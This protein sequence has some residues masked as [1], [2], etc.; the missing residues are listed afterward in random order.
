M[1]AYLSEERAPASSLPFGRADIEQTIPARF[2]QIVRC[3]PENIALTGEGHQWT[4]AEL[5][6]RVNR[7]AHAIRALTSPHVG[8]VAFLLKQSPEMVIATLAVLKAGKTYL[9]IHPEMPAA[10]QRDIVQDAAPELIVTSG[11]LSSRAREIAASKCEILVVDEIDERYSDQNLELSI[12]PQDPSSIFYTSGTTGN[13]KGVVKSH[14]AV[15]HRVWLSTQHDVIVPA[16]RQSLLT[17]ASFSASESDMFAALLQGARVCVFDIGSRGFAEFRRW[18]EEQKLTLLHPPVLLFRGFLSTLEERNLFPSVRLVALAGDVVL[19]ADVEKWRRHFAGSCKL[20]HRFSTAETALLT[21]AHI[22]REAAPETGAVTAGRPVADKALELLDETGR[23][24]AQGEAGELVV[25]SCYLADGYWRHPEETAKVFRADPNVPGQKIYGTGDL[26][27]FLPDGSLEFLGRREHLAKIR[28]Y[29]VD[30]REV[31][32]A[33][34]GLDGVA[35][36]AVIV[37]KEHDEDRLSA[38]IVMQPGGALDTHALRERLRVHLPEWKIPTR[39]ESIPALPTTL[40]GKVDRQRLHSMA[41]VAVDQTKPT[42]ASTLEAELAD[43]WQVTL[44]RETVG[45]DD[46]FLDL[47]GDSISAMMTLNWIERLYGV[48]LTPAEFY[49]Q[50]TIRQLAALL[51]KSS[52]PKMEPAL[53]APAAENGADAFVELLN[54]HQV[55]CVFVN[56]GTDTAPILESIAKFQ[57][58]GRRT[59]RLVLCLHESLAM[60]AAHGYFMVTGRVQVV[61]VHVDVGTQNLGANL[62]NAQRGR[63]GVVICAGRAPYTVDGNVAGGRNRYNHWIQEQFNQAGIVQ[64]YVKWHY[65]LTRR[66]NLSLAVDRAFQIAGTDPAGPVYLTLPRE[67]LMENADAPLPEGR[68]FPPASPQ[69]ADPASIA[70]A[71]RWLI[72]AENPLILVAYAG[73]NPEAVFAL[74]T[75][76]ELIAAP[77][78]ESRQRVNFPSSHPLHLGYSPVRALPHADC[79]LIVDHDVP[80]VPAQSRP[81]PEAKII[82]IDNDALKRDIP[83]WG[84]P[85]DL[86]MQADSCV[87]LRALADEIERQLTPL[88]RHRMEERRS[89]VSAEHQAQASRRQDRVLETSANQP[90]APDWAAHCLN[91]I[92][93]RDTV[94]VS[95]AVTNSPVLWSHLQLDAPGTY[96]QSLGSG[97]GWG[98]GAALGAKLADPSKT[99]ICVVGDGSWVFA[100]PIAAHWAAEQNHVPFLTVIFNNQQYHATAEAILTVSPEGSA[101]K[102]GNYPACDLPMPPMYARVAEALGLWAKTVQEP[103]ELLSV[104]RQALDEVR[105]GRSALVDIG[106]SAPSAGPHES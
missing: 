39:I 8:C 48:R 98:L 19:P 15:L 47:G 75:L 100:N 84:F 32:S 53:R 6:Y 5:N 71:A 18:I 78:V 31:E 97:L 63:A 35:A 74:V 67:V 10:A 33:I 37:R 81:K 64:G 101:R 2:E 41:A 22:E 26:G 93:D 80:W 70:R 28:G 62:H 79:V 52:A 83:L 103:A 104:L 34:T 86:A 58:Q 30:T 96:Y 7:I 16:D 38:F 42:A 43:I 17:H 73:R 29:R 102:S 77:V 50:A 23:A 1:E 85:M 88:D 36:A 49:P 56:P 105:G 25:R 68:G 60:A 91:Q 46:H 106:V 87:T 99:V 11:E 89:G 92:L 61:M 66:E 90:I 12:A 72:D 76:A 94:I 3:F 57:A 21:V 40:S 4:Y 51:S 27:R 45:L 54:A 59:P 24:V 82:Q 13:P 20:L 44:R 9:G 69:A 65:E 14:R 95:E 55:D